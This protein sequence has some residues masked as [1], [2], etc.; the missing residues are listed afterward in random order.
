MA[1]TGDRKE[2]FSHKKRDAHNVIPFFLCKAMN[3]KAEFYKAVNCLTA[4]VGFAAL[5]P[6]NI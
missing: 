1:D 4:L 5:I 2:R 6:D 3:K